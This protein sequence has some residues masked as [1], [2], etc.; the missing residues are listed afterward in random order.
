MTAHAATVIAALH[1]SQRIKDYGSY[2]GFACVLGLA[3]LSLLYF[4]QAREVKRLREWAGRAP[5]RDADLQA[6]VTA[7]AQQRAATPAPAAAAAARPAAAAATPAGQA[8][9]AKPA[10]PAPAAGAQ[11]AVPGAQP[12]V[13]GAQPS[14]QPAATPKPGVPAPATAA[15]AAAGAASASPA[16]KPDAP[17]D[18]DG[19]T[20]PPST[21]RPATPAGASPSNGAVDQPTQI[22]PA[23][24][25]AAAAAKPAPRPGQPLR[26]P[27]PAP[28]T[29]GGEEEHSP[30]R[31][32]LMI[33]GGVLA[34]VAVVLVLVLTV[35]SGSDNKKAPNTIGNTPASSTGASSKGGSKST[36]DKSAPVSRGDV[37]VA[38]LNGTTIPGLA[39]GAGTK[40][41][42][43]G[44]KLGT[45]TNAPDQARSAT[46]VAYKAGHEAEAR[47]VARL[48]QVGA[49]AV[50]P[51]DQST[52]VVA[53]QDAD[54]VVTVGADQSQ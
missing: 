20:P 31:T 6:R 2:A 45:V 29:A 4:A 46:I 44:F 18:G 3:V 25:A 17:V 32:T 13:P 35:F 8:A 43:A 49:D 24:A 39:R 14:A 26:P 30:L 52:A 22:T 23:P 28:A 21:P 48:I 51:I 19:A 16:V 37:T 7:E 11:P 27:P 5:E 33:V 40:L 12:A 36:T 47:V 9:A 1:V 34:V 53:G 41:Q 15:A 50:K 38:V 10:T 54:V 42:N